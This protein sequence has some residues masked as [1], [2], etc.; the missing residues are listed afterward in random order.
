MECDNHQTEKSDKHPCLESLELRSPSTKK[1]NHIR[2]PLNHMRVCLEHERVAC[3][4]C[5]VQTVMKDQKQYLRQSFAQPIIHGDQLRLYPRV[6]IKLGIWTSAVSEKKLHL[7]SDGNRVGSIFFMWAYWGC[8]KLKSVNTL[9][10]EG[11]FWTAEFSGNQRGAYVSPCCFKYCCDL[12]SDCAVHTSRTS[13]QMYE[14]FAWLR[15]ASSPLHL[16]CLDKAS[17]L[18]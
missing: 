8:S 1:W 3:C 4:H 2:W 9:K 6:K 11:C 13:A 10:G 18:D 17:S 14:H 12:S 16:W 15:A 7:C 5:T